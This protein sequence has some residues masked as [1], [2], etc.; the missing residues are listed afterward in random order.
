MHLKSYQIDGRLL[1]TG[2]ANFSASSLKRQDDDLVVIE[3]AEAPARQMRRL[4]EYRKGLR[5]TSDNTLYRRRNKRRGRRR[6]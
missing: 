3:S 4:G 5:L 6:S 1:R 2:A